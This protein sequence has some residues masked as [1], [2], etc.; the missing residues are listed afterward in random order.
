MPAAT[1]VKTGSVKSRD[2][3][4]RPKVPA[5]ERRAA[6]R[7]RGPH[8]I[9]TLFTLPD[10]QTW[11]TDRR[12]RGRG[13][14]VISECRGRYGAAFRASHGGGDL[15][16]FGHLADRSRPWR[17][18]GRAGS[19]WPRSAAGASTRLVGRTADCGTRRR[20]GRAGDGD[21]RHPPRPERRPGHRG[22]YERGWSA[23]RPRRYEPPTD[24]P[25]AGG[26]ASSDWSAIRARRLRHA[27]G[28]AGTDRAVSWST[29][30]WSIADLTGRL[31][32]GWPPWR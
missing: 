15:P 1:R 32:Q 17:E 14:A 26:R 31:E 10:G 9:L 19:R 3:G 28:P 23:L 30:G 18:R 29:T 16:M 7:R 21:D 13:S 6:Q 27:S 20:R 5:Q 24:L 22:A 2:G 25:T 12:A 4:N 8:R 11:I